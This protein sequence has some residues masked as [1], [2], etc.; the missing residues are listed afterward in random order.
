[1]NGRIGRQ[2]RGHE[3][4]DVNIRAIVATG[5]GIAVLGAI[6]LILTVGVYRYY[7][8][9][10]PEAPANPMSAPGPQFP[11]KPRIEEHPSAE[12]EQLR[13]HENRMLTTYGWADKK[14]GAVRIPIDR[15][16]EFQLSRGFPARSEK[17]K[18]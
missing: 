10:R 9:P 7:S 16:L 17:V 2:S 12:L 6:V 1:M 15:A 3:V 13:E 4:K 5:A 8:E 14:S 18:K 11:P